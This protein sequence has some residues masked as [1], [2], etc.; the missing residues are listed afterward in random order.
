MGY[1][2]FKVFKELVP[3]LKH[4]KE[5]IFF[6]GLDNYSFDITYKLYTLR[7]QHEFVMCEDIILLQVVNVRNVK[8]FHE[9]VNYLD[10]FRYVLDIS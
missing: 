6:G 2:S 10:S 7:I 5:V 1:D 3:D 9:I 8:G 4:E